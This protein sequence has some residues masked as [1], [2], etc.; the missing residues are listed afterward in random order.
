MR[1]R[2]SA[3]QD[4][5]VFCFCESDLMCELAARILS[6]KARV[7]AFVLRT[8]AHKPSM[9]KLDMAVER[10]DDNCVWVA[11]LIRVGASASVI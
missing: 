7:R 9:T 1:P 8:P 2:C 6:H 5:N 4:A 11:C 3:N 10:S